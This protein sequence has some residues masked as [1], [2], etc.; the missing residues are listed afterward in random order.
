MASTHEP[1][2]YAVTA[3][4]AVIITRL[5]SE[6][7]QAFERQQQAL[8]RLQDTVNKLVTKYGDGKAFKAFDYETAELIL[9]A[10]ESNSSED[11]TE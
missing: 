5:E 4:E 8:A 7:R 1:Q 9:S 6:Y 3:P 10:P 11:D 2:R